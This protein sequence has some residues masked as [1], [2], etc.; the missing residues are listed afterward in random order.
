LQRKPNWWARN[1]PNAPRWLRAQ[2]PYLDY[3]IIPDDVTALLALRRGDID[4]YPMP[5]AQEFRRL[6]H[7]A[8]TAKLIFRTADSYNLTMAGFNTQRPALRNPLTRRALSMLFDIPGLIHATQQGLAYRSVSLI[9]PHD[10]RAYNDSLP[11]VAFNPKAALALLRQAGWHQKPDGTWWQNGKQLAL[12][13]IYRAGEAEHETIA[14]Q[15][16]TAAKQIGI[17]ISPQPR[18]NELLQQ[19]LLKGKMDMYVRTISGNPFTY[20]FMPILHSRGIGIYNYA[21]FQNQENN[22]L[23]EAITLEQNEL[24]QAKL[25]RRFQS[26][27]QQ[28][29]PLVALYFTRQRLI[30]SRRLAQVQAISVRPGYDVLCLKL[31]SSTE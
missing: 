25:L 7:S 20:N 9:N 17:P 31:A 11:L 29:S 8:D 14:L 3:R 12:N 1:V 4:L 23:I 16:R 26:L 30:A 10:K 15:L 22:H 27:L 18:N 13:I 19:Q 24:R 28:E 21:R 5:S 2:A 6:Q